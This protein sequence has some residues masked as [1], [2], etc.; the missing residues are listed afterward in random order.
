LPEFVKVAATLRKYRDG[1]LAAINYGVSNGML[2]GLN[3]KIGMLKHRAFGLHSA[4]ALTS[5]VYLCCS[6]LHINLPT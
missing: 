2:E 3:N 5:M 1:V 6:N 4:A